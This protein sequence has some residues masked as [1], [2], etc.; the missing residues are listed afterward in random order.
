M[1]KINR[2]FIGS[3]NKGK[4][5]EISDLLPKTIEKISP[6]KLNIDSPEEYG[7]S[8]LENSEIKADYF[9]KKSNMI[10]ISDDSGL[11]VSCLNGMP[12]I[13]SARWADQYGSFD[14]A[15]SEVLNKISKVNQNKKFK[16]TRA[17]FVCSLTI[18]WPK[19]KKISEIGE[20]HGNIS[21]KK[22]KNGFGYDP[23]FIPT[24]YSKTFGEMDYREKLLIDHRFIAYKKLEKKIKDYF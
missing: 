2:I 21:E 19:G 13:F 11:E 17:K 12:G 1:N 10:T 4:F 15:M 14:N 23:I 20:V 3:N 7:K 8:F 18:K 24:G 22:G 16:D 9:C 5:R 6:D